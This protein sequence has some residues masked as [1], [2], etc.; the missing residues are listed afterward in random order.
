M[1]KIEQGNSWLGGIWWLRWEPN[2]PFSL[3]FTYRKKLAF[4]IENMEKM[5]Y[6]FVMVFVWNVILKYAPEHMPA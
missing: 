1:R 6:F 5:I 4:S 2:V 3:K